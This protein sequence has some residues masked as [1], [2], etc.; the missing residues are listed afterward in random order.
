A[1]L[2]LAGAAAL[3]ACFSSGAST[4][5]IVANAGPFKAVSTNVSNNDVWALN[6][7]II[8]SFNQPVD[9]ASVGFGSVILRPVSAAVQG[10][11]VTGRFQMVAGSG[12]RAIVFLPACPTDANNSNGAF[13]PG[14]FEYELTLPTEG[15]FGSSVLRNQLGTQ[16]SIG[17]TRRFFS[18]APPGDALFI[19]TDPGAPLVVS[20]EFPSGLNLFTAPDATIAITFNQAVNASPTNLNLA[21]IAVYYSTSTVTALGGGPP[22]PGQFPASNVVPGRLVLIDNCSSGGALIY[23][24]VTGLLPPDRYLRLVVKS[25]FADISGQTNAVDQTFDYA[26]PRLADFYGDPGFGDSEPAVDE[27]QEFFTTSANVDVNAF[28]TSPPATVKGGRATASFD[29]PGEPVPAGADFTVTNNMLIVIQTDGVFQ[30]TDSLGKEFTIDNGVMLV[31]DLT[32]DAGSTL[33]GRGQN[34]LLIYAV[35][36]IDVQGSLIANGNRAKS[37]LAL[38]SP[39]IPEIGAVGELGGGRGGDASKNTVAETLRGDSGDGPFGESRGGGQGGEGG[40]QT[41]WAF[42]IYGGAD[43]INTVIRQLIAGGGAGGN[44]AQTTNE[45]V[46]WTRW[47]GGDWPATFDD[48]GP[49]MQAA[50]HTVFNDPAFVASYFVGGENGL[51]GTDLFG[52]RPEPPGAMPPMSNGV[53][54]MEDVGRETT[55]TDNSPG[56]DPAWTNPAVP[57]TFNFGLPSVGPDPGFTN[58]S[59]FQAGSG[60][61]DFWGKR[62]NPD[63]TVTTGELLAPW[64]GYGGGASGD[65]TVVVRVDADGDSFLDPL[66]DTYP[67]SLWPTG[68]TLDYLKGA[69]GGGGGGQ[70]VVMAIGAIILGPNAVVSANG[71]SGAPGESIWQTTS[72]VSGSGAGTGG[73]VVLNS[74]TGINLAQ[75]DPGT[76]PLA[77]NY[78]DANP[79]TDL[80]EFEIVQAIGGRRGWAAS[81]RRN[82]EIGGVPDGN[83]DFM[84]G[85]GGAGANGV[86]QIHV[87]DPVNNISFHPDVDA[88]VK[89]YLRNGAA[90]GPADTDRLEEVLDA[91]TA[92]ASF[93]LIPFFSPVSQV[94]SKWFDSGLAGLHAP[95]VGVAGPFPD[96]LDPAFVD[97]AGIDALTG[98]VTS[99]TM[100]V[101]AGAE[102]TTISSANAIL[103]PFSMTITNASAFLNDLFL[104]NPNLLVGYQVHPDRL[105]AATGFEIVSAKYFP[106]TDVLAIVTSTPDGAMTTTAATRSIRERFFRIDTSDQK[107]RLPDTAAVVFEFQGADVSPVNPNLPDLGTATPWTS[108][109]SVLKGRRFV[110]VRVTFDINT[111]APVSNVTLD[112]EKPSVD[113]YKVPFVW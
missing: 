103:T 62:L 76:G 37:P 29:F 10:Q 107:D 12:N 110:R 77:Q 95:T 4:K 105:D 85:R 92:P 59:V 40:V 74:A 35:G 108:D 7:P 69:P 39:Q 72:Q 79:I 9:P 93:A 56:L 91:Y 96:F 87:P 19:D 6:R 83:S 75:I 46:Q 70:L 17:L 30:V 44:F 36:E 34:P 1:A 27:I 45:S 53:F 66:T 112:S 38:N 106:V 99:T 57:P 58:Q 100:V 81:S 104:K 68:S 71:G 14:G 51:R 88:A 94:Q 16:L 3:P 32:I 89:W 113:Y 41:Q 111:G 18:P 82:T 101:D 15:A 25:L 84:A 26:T 90:T 43:P 8:I 98:E 42:Q 61:D 20:T 54:G 21:N 109:L 97:F 73:H 23:F 80:G 48:A 2:A 55:N 86:V 49:D 31:E 63:G 50:R 11:P 28:L 22:P 33:R 24:Q 78:F 13:R 5:K 52:S 47:A 60:A 67:D 102:I 64:A 65:I